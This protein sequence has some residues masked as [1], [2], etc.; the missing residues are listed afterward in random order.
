MKATFDRS[1]HFALRSFPLVLIFGVA[2]TLPSL[3]ASTVDSDTLKAILA[4]QKITADN[5]IVT[6]LTILRVLFSVGFSWSLYR[7]YDKYN[8][9]SN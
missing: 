8:L 4:T 6:I 2:I 5:S 7:M 1:A 3:L 9:K